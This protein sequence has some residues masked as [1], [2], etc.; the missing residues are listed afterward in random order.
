[1]TQ[2]ESILQ[3]LDT[4]WKTDVKDRI[5]HQL[6]QRSEI[7]EI[8]FGQL[9][10]D[11][12]NGCAGQFVF[13]QDQ[14]WCFSTGTDLY[15][16]VGDVELRNLL[17]ELH[18]SNGYEGRRHQLT[19]PKIGRIVS[20]AADRLTDNQFFDGAQ[21]GLATADGFLLLTNGRIELKDHNPNYRARWKTPI[22]F[23]P[24]SDTEATERQLEKA[25]GN[26]ENVQAFLEILGATLFGLGTHFERMLVLVGE[27][28]NGKSTLVNIM[29][30]MIPAYMR[31]SVPLNALKT[32]YDRVQL[33]R[34]IL[35][36]LEEMPVLSPTDVQ[37]IKNVITGGDIQARQISQAAFTMRPI[38]QHVICTNRLPSMHEN[39]EALRRRLIVIRLNQTIPADRRD[40]DFAQKLFNEH[41]EALLLL[42]VRALENALKRGRLYEPSASTREVDRWLSQSDCVGSFLK[43]HVEHTGN[44]KDFIP[45]GEMYDAYVRYANQH[46]FPTPSSSREFGSRLEAAGFSKTKS[47]NMRWVG[48]RLQADSREDRED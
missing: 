33:D 27:G 47:S 2:S 39:N 19:K 29:C 31:S 10:A 43:E 14:F 32:E 40:L 9:L 26:P 34:K 36:T 42:S 46:D 21:Q 11:A 18:R 24:L 8:E 44:P 48:V 5:S 25:L 1:M 38:A 22:V 20:I 37:L 7:D 41:K 3:H 6:E 45:V 30:Q 15:E 17:Y 12:L 28:A 35:N 4:S 23:N 16:P 13:A